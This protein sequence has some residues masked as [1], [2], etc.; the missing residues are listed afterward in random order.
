MPTFLTSQAEQMRSEYNPLRG[1]TIAR[2]VQ[3][4]EAAQRGEFADLT[5]AYK[6]A[7]ETDA[8]LLALVERR[9]AALCELNWY[10]K[11]VSEETRGFEK[12]LAAE[13]AAALRETYE[14]IGNL[15][16]AI[17]HFEMA[18]FRGFSVVQ[19]RK[20]GNRI[21]HLELLDQWNFVRDGFYGAWYWN[22]S[23]RATSARALG[24]GQKLKPTDIWVHEVKRHVD[25]LG[26]LKFVRANLSEKDWDYFIDIYGIPG[27][28]IIGPANVPQGKEDEYR[29][30]A[31]AAAR[32]QSGYLPFGADV[33]FPSEVRGSSP[34][35]GRLRY[36]SEQLVLAATGGKLTM[37]TAPGSGTLAG[38]AHQD[39]FDQIARARAAKIS[40]L[41][42]RK[43]DQAVLAEAFP[44]RPRLAYWDLAAEEE[45]DMNSVITQIQNLSTAGFM[46]DPE[47]VEERTGYRLQ[48]STPPANDVKVLNRGT[49]TAERVEA[50][51][52]STQKALQAAALTAALEAERVDAAPLAE[53]LYAAL[54]ALESGNTAAYTAALKKLQDD[55]PGLA[56]SLLASPS[57]ATALENTLAAAALNGW[58]EGAMGT[59]S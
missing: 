9:T 34:F 3:M 46:V 4:F 10:V 18:A 41:F 44:D 17:E 26:L 33:K 22:P 48:K 27:A 53:R 12:N 58:A 47:D 40:E 55:L 30:A 31:E 14:G 39:A 43:L 37:L 2:C 6:F 8:D 59:K 24:D 28:F 29:L 51:G 21:T 16:E 38:G 19:P 7:E 57:L 5:W 20:T 25:R 50:R 49:P 1:L 54:E 15:Y 32:A 42:Q 56:E 35:E 45:Q 36:L 52:E 11:E 13:Q 23:A